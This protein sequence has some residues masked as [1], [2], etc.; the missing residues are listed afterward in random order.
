VTCSL[1]LLL[2][3]PLLSHRS[4]CVRLMIL[5]E[6]QTATKWRALQ[7]QVQRPPGRPAV[8]RYHGRGR[9]Q[10]ATL[11]GLPDITAGDLYGRLQRLVRPLRTLV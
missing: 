6:V 1:L 8:A 7:T 3:L 11:P 4:G 9:H 2:Q 10:L 5:H